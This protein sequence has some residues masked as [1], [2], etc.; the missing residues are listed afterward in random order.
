[1]N[2]FEFFTDD[3]YKIAGSDFANLCLYGKG[4]I[5]C[6]TGGVAVPMAPGGTVNFYRSQ[7]PLLEIAGKL[8]MASPGQWNGSWWYG[9]GPIAGWVEYWSFGP[10]TLAAAPDGL[11]MYEESGALK[12]SSA[13]PFLRVLGRVEVAG[14]SYQSADGTRIYKPL[15]AATGFSGVNAFALGSTRAYWTSAQITDGGSWWTDTWRHVRGMH[16]AA[17]G[18]FFSST[19]QTGQQRFAGGTGN[20]NRSPN[21]AAPMTLLVADV[22]GL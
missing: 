21:G 8:R 5:H 22:S 1:M 3:G 2:G 14:D 6:P 16:L 7:Y 9:G 13:R 15:S 19:I 10:P 12:F 4:T 20:F 17:D 11:E 18:S